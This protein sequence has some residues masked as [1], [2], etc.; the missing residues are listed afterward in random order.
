MAS[1]KEPSFQERTAAA[2]VA[3]EK[4]LTKLKT[5]APLSAEE[6]AARAAKAA[7]REAARLAKVAAMHAAREAKREEAERAREEARAAAAA[8][9]APKMTDE[10][11]KALRDAKY[12]AR[13]NRKGK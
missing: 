3:R 9:E 11:R 12:A 1:Y 10:E 8:S 4:A 6:L 2:A 5:K 7:E 13:K